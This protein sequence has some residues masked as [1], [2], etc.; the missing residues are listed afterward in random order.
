MI[1]EPKATIL[2][3]DHQIDRK[4]EICACILNRDDETSLCHNHLPFL[5]FVVPE[6]PLKQV[7][8]LFLDLQEERCEFYRLI[9][10]KPLVVLVRGKT[11]VVSQI[12][13]L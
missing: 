10:D 11:D 13:L 4:S 2:F 8:G 7:F 3:L 9:S 6:I 1:Y 5:V 12:V